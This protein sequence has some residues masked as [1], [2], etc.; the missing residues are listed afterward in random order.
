MKISKENVWIV[1]NDQHED[2][3]EVAVFYDEKQA[4]DFLA[5]AEIRVQNTNLIR[6]LEQTNEK[7]RKLQNALI[8]TER[9]IVKAKELIEK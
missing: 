4:Y 7:N 6:A 3:P 9:H 1:Y 2:L 5:M 8:E